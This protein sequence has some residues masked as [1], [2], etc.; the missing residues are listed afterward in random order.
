MLT[1]LSLC[2]GLTLSA[3]ARQPYV[4]SEAKLRQRSS[5]G[6][7]EPQQIHLAS[8]SDGSD[9]MVVTWSTIGSTDMRPQ[10][11][12]V[13]YYETSDPSEVY[14]AHGT[15]TNFTAEPGPADATWQLIHR[16]HLTNLTAGTSYTYQCGNN[17]RN[18]SDA[19]EFKTYPNGSDWSP[20][21]LVYGDFGLVDDHSLSFLEAEIGNGTSDLI[22]HNGDFAYDL[23]NKDGQVGDDFMNAIQPFAA[24]VPYMVSPGNHESRFNF[25]NY[26]NRFTMPAFE[27]T[28]NLWYSV[29]IGPV[30]LV[31]VDTEIENRLYPSMDPGLIARHKAW[32]LKD[33]EQVDR[34]KTP[35]IITQGHRPTYCS[36]T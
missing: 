25:S 8:G 16:V 24:R 35:W 9:E 11:T 2:V 7:D 34:E 27:E 30:H 14:Y 36:N 32:L 22:L 6:H 15:V 10:A 29:D 26:R 5:F 21:F 18:L 13:K 4:L 17:R 28:E 23:Y 31:S 3:A 1:L 19:F 20:R 33:L 12:T